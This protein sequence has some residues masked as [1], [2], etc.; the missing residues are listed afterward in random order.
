MALRWVEHPKW[1]GEPI[2]S[3]S[4]PLRQDLTLPIS[5]PIA[6]ADA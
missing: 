5:L 3:P 4:G 6:R 1:C 2:A